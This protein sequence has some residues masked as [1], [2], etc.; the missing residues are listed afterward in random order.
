MQNVQC[1]SEDFREHFVIR[2]S[3][4]DIHYSNNDLFAAEGLH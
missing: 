3:L 2:Y 1:R 4:F